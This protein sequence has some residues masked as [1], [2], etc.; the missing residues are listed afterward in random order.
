LTFV[1]HDDQPVSGIGPAADRRP[2]V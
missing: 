2:R 1:S